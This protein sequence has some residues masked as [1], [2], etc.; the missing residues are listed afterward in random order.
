MEH[1]SF[2]NPPSLRGLRAL[3]FWTNLLVFCALNLP[4]R[5]WFWNVC[6]HDLVCSGSGTFACTPRHPPWHQRPERPANRERRGQTRW[7]TLTVVIVGN[8]KYSSPHK[9]FTA[10]VQCLLQLVVCDVF[11]LILAWALSWTGQSAGGTLS[12][13]HLTG[14]HPRSLPVM[15]TLTL[16]MTTEYVYSSENDAKV[17]TGCG[18]ASTLGLI[19]KWRH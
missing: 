2:R 17:F 11:Q 5:A 12:S 1:S 18:R 15:R 19:G 9:S 8:F 4:V 14:W 16:L 7:A 10:L 3:D 13:A 6:S